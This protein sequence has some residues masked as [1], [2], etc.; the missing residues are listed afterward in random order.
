ML[1]ELYILAGTMKSLPSLIALLLSLVSSSYAQ[2]T[3]GVVLSTVKDSS[4]AVVANASVQLI[5][6]GENVKRETRTSENGD[7]E[8]LNT[9]PG[10]YS[11]S[12]NHAGFRTFSARDLQLVARQTLRVDA[13]LEVGEVAESV[14]VQTSAGVIGRASCRER[15]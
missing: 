4:G 14:E 1:H 12:I 13:V 11:V 9:K 3:F 5:N 7:Y 8:F 10:T 15:V 2:S 6:S